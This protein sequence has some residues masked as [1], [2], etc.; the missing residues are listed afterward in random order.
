MKIMD[1]K[2]FIIAQLARTKKKKYEQYVV[3]RIVHLLNDLDIKFVTQQ[4]VKRPNGIA[5]VDLYFP[6]I[7]LFIEVNEGQHEAE[8]H[9][10][11]DKVRD[12]DIVNATNHKPVPIATTKPIEEINREIDKIVETIKHKVKSDSDFIPWDIE[13]EF[14]SETYINRGYIDTADNVAFRTIKDACNCFGHSYKGYQR[15]SAPHPHKSDTILWFPKLYENEGWDNSISD[16]EETIRERSKDDAYSAEHVRSHKANKEKHK[17]KRVVFA[18]VKGNLG[19]VLYRFRGLYELNL[20]E[21][22]EETGLVWNRTATRVET[23][24]QLLQ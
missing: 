7:P 23:Y 11:A 4:Y 22:N 18:R 17:H 16:D 24:P 15:A 21:S 20:H 2:E 19:D 14:S 6:Q 12:A 10:E 9:I 5:L 1:K 8:A 13:A 3:T